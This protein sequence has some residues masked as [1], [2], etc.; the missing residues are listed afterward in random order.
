MKVPDLPKDVINPVVITGIEALGRGN[1]LQKLDLFL[2]G[3]AATVGAEA[4]AQYLNVGEYFKRRATS[5]GIKTDGL[6]KSQ[7]EIQQQMQ[8][9]QQQAQQE[10][11]LKS[12]DQ[13]LLKHLMTKHVQQQQP[14][15]RY[16]NG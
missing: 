1:D 11:M 5:L 9:M 13:M 8:T 12:L 10:Q 6:V 16:N 3:A 2:Q 15:R 7:E 4:M 14:R